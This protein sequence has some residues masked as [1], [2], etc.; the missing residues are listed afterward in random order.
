MYGT[1][2]ESV[3]ALISGICDVDLTQCYLPGSAS[4]GVNL[5]DVSMSIVQNIKYTTPPQVAKKLAKGTEQQ[6]VLATW[7]ILRYPHI[8]RHANFEYPFSHLLPGTLP[9]TSRTPL[10]SVSYEI[11]AS[12]TT[13]DG[14]RST[15]SL[16]LQ[17]G[18]SVI[19]ITD[20]TSVRIFPPTTLSLSM[21]LP[22]ALFPNS[23]VHAEMRIEGLVG[24]TPPGSTLKYK[25]WLLK[26]LNWRVDEFIKVRWG[27]RPEDEY[28]HKQPLG[29]GVHKSGW[30]SDYTIKDGVV[31]FD[32]AEFC[33]GV[34]SRA[35]KDM[36][37]P[38]S[39]IS[40]SHQLI[41]EL[42]IAEEVVSKPTVKQG[43][44]SGSAR[45]LR[46][47]FALPVVD[48]PGLGI[49]WE[50][51]V[52]PMYADIPLSP[53]QYNEVADLPALEEYNGL[54]FS[55]SFSPMI[56]PTLRHVDPQMRPSPRLPPRSFPSPAVGASPMPPIQS[57]SLNGS[58]PSISSRSSGDE[59]EPPPMPP[60]PAK[61][62]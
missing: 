10:F 32:C 58:S 25:R 36:N 55:P 50:D 45:V 6:N 42:L 37:D 8:L 20:K 15:A 44:L 34:L 27:E 39:G 52:P 33:P 7:D 59:P 43:V 17:I 2:Q 41:C 49:S 51:E 24:P 23:Q 28:E 12:A 18:R 48:R 22:S 19:N 62:R 38:V 14:K 61:Y 3:G 11:R 29:F 13:Q 46:M 54:V 9:P 56:S 35:S 40:V 5:Q 26:R 16:P 21:I 53:P 4:E 60:M 57:L 30:K 1:P 47:Q 31:E